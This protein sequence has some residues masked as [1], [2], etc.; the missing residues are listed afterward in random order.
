MIE[1]EFDASI[2]YWTDVTQ[3]T[4]MLKDIVEVIPEMTYL[5]KA[6]FPYIFKDLYE[7]GLYIYGKSEPLVKFNTDYIVDNK[8]VRFKTYDEIINALNKHDILTLDGY[9]LLSKNSNKIYGHITPGYPVT[10]DFISFIQTYINRV[11]NSEASILRNEKEVLLEPHLEYKDID[12]YVKNKYSWMM[13]KDDYHQ[14]LYHQIRTYMYV[15][16]DTIAMRY[17]KYN[18]LT[19]RLKLK[20]SGYIVMELIPA[21]SSRLYYAKKY[22]TEIKEQ[23]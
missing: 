21:I 6:V 7:G 19:C 11:V 23:L 4:P 2:G 20:E 5:E 3:Y 9:L 14:A 1:L 22:I 17:N 13:H 8:V 12:D 10:E 15:Q 18:P 16:Y